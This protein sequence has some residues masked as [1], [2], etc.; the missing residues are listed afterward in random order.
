MICKLCNKDKKLLKQSHIIPDFAYKGI[1]DEKHRIYYGNFNN[2]ERGTLIPSSPYDKN[3]LCK[4]CDGDI[5]G[6]L[7][8]YASNALYGNNLGN[9]KIKISRIKSSDGLISLH[10]DNIDYKKFKLYILSI[11]WRASVSKHPFFKNIDLGKNEKQIGEMILKGEPKDFSKFKTCLILADKH[12]NLTTRL[13]SEPRK[14]STSSTFYIF[15]IN[16]LF[17]MINISDDNNL[18]LFDYA[19]LKENNTINIPILTGSLLLSFY[20]NVIGL[21]LR[22]E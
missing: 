20:D 12:K 18:E 16:R 2:P 17:Y 3:I 6:G 19:G 22:K 7:E 10:I 11:L 14:I 5:I 1:Y 15:F 9:G 4:E 13:V 8:N 21:K